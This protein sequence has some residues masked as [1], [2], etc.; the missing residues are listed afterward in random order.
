MLVYRCD[1]CKGDK[2]EGQISIGVLEYKGSK[3]DLCNECLKKYH[4]LE[5]A[6][7][8]WKKS[9]FHSIY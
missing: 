3:K 9:F 6:N 8:E 5:E 2:R 1:H 7:S 4:R